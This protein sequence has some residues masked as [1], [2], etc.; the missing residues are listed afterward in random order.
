MGMKGK[1][2]L[3]PIG[4]ESRDRNKDIAR[5]RKRTRAG[6]RTG[7]HSMAETEKTITI[8]DPPAGW[9]Y[10]FPRQ[11]KPLPNETLADTL[12]RDGYPEKEDPDF[13]AN[14]CRF[15]ERPK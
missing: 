3:D 15:W 10:G 5:K 13:A 14:H 9:R 7:D 12:R 8:Y 4:D 1:R 6:S 2:S 11:F